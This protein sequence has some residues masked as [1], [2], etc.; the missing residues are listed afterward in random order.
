MD[1]RR[2]GQTIFGLGLVF[3]MTF[4]F[5]RTPSDLCAAQLRAL[6][7][8]APDAEPLTEA[9]HVPL[10]RF[11]PFLATTKGMKD[12]TPTSFRSTRPGY[13]ER[14]K[15]P[16]PN[17]LVSVACAGHLLFFTKNVGSYLVTVDVGQ[18]K[19]LSGVGGLFGGPA[20]AWRVTNT[21]YALNLYASGI[22]LEALVLDVRSGE[23]L[24][25]EGPSRFG[26][27]KVALVV[28]KKGVL[29]ENT[30]W[31]FP[32]AWERVDL[33]RYD[34]TRGNVRRRSVGLPSCSFKLPPN[35]YAWRFTLEPSGLILR[36]EVPPRGPTAP[37]Y[38][39]MAPPIHSVRG[40]AFRA[41]E[42]V[43]RTLK[44]CRA[45]AERLLG[46]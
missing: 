44:P 22:N 40:S 21:V 27:L 34:V 39:P 17:H 12:L 37:L 18:R 43:S 8:Q 15:A 19:K 2:L 36:A 13:G 20:Q 29:L 45:V 14:E 35:A 38:N 28:P 30:S 16:G 31:G 46:N 26:D 41:G 10:G 5:A 6:G 1:V 32:S 7:A 4:A 11:L 42:I 33:L 23:V 24:F 25:Y 3:V 9:W